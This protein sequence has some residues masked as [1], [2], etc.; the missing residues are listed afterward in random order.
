M[1]ELMQVPEVIARVERLVDLLEL[2]DKWNRGVFDG[3]AYEHMLPVFDSAYRHFV[4]PL[5]RSNEQFERKRLER[6]INEVFGRNS[7]GFALAPAHHAMM[8]LVRDYVVYGQRLEY[9][10]SEW[11]NA[12]LFSEYDHSYNWSAVYGVI[13]AAVVIADVSALVA[14]TVASIVG[15]ATAVAVATG[16]GVVATIAGAGAAYLT[17]L[18]Y[19]RQR[20]RIREE[21][22]DRIAE[23]E[24]S[25]E[26][27]D[28]LDLQVRRRYNA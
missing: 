9:P 20:D 19:T 2:R 22:S 8:D 21:I 1:T 26:D 14:A 12:E 23:G 18:H 3:C 4:K 11:T 25:Q 13:A 28:T 5:T 15:A 24:I 6:S 7:R 17:Y 16:V 27:W 10:I